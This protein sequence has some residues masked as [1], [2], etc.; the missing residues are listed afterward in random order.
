M[1]YLFCTNPIGFVIYFQ[2][3]LPCILTLLYL[4][5]KLSFLTRKHSISKDTY[6]MYLQ[7]YYIK[8]ILLYYIFIY[9]NKSNKNICSNNK[10]RYTLY[11]GYLTYQATSNQST[12]NSAHLIFSSVI[13]YSV[14]IIKTR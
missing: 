11:N 7:K 6:A 10:L 12:R 4:G 2:L 5:S 14:L 9:I 3:C 8:M 1:Y 13:Q